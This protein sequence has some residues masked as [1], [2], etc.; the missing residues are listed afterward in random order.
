MKKMK[1]WKQRQNRSG[2]LFMLPWII[3]FAVFTAFPFIATIA[4]SFT[5]VNSTILGY[6]KMV[7]PYTFVIVVVSFIIAYILEH[8]VKLKG[9]FR[10]I[11]FLPVIIMSG[12]VM[13]KLLDT[14]VSDM[15]LFAGQSYSDIFII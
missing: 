1:T 15:Q 10:T 12:P 14:K 9:F 7:I 8:I 13:A 11:Y 5:N 6:L 3:G 4:L 2:Y